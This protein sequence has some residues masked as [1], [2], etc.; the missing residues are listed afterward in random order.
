METM[1]TAYGREAHRKT[2][3]KIE[4]DGKISKKAL[5]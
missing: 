2:V 1:G 3:D 4:V 5:R